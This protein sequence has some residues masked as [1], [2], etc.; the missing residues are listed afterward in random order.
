[1]LANFQH[2][3][4]VPVGEVLKFE[5]SWILRK[6]NGGITWRVSKFK[7]VFS[8]INQDSE[9]VFYLTSSCE[10][11]RATPGWSRSSIPVC[12]CRRFSLGWCWS[13][14]CWTCCVSS[15][16]V[17]PSSHPDLPQRPLSAA[18]EHRQL[19]RGSTQPAEG[20]PSPF[21]ALLTGCCQ[22]GEEGWL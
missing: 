8:L 7:W 9:P 19:Q 6:A 16:W 1:M 5:E 18:V 12:G 22:V 10:W 15:C 14:W 21:S 20:P 11:W 13:S 2:V 17:H 4:G 3:S